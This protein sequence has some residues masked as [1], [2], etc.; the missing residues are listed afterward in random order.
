LRNIVSNET[1]D[2]IC[3][4]RYLQTRNVFTYPVPSTSYD[5]VRVGRLGNSLESWPL[6]NVNCK[7]LRV[8]NFVGCSI[9]MDNTF[10][11]F[12][13]IMEENYYISI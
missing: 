4:R 2:F 5:F 11:V 1:G 10:A 3:G 13:L 9:E 7:A 6:I 12:P 8:P